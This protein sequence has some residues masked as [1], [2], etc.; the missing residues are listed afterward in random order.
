MNCAHVERRDTLFA[1]LG[2]VNLCLYWFHPLAWLV[3]KRLAALSEHACDDR[4]IGLTGAPIPYARHLLEFAAMLVDHRH[5][6]TT[7]ASRWPT[8]A[9]SAR[10]S[11]PSSIVAERPPDRCRAGVRS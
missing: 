11:T 9:T 1:V 2:A 7:G 6:P 3:P 10:A 8:A 4:A 5:R